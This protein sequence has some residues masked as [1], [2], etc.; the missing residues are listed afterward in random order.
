MAR[1]RRDA[2]TV[3]TFADHEIIVPAQSLRKALVSGDGELG[4]D[5]EAIARAEAALT[6]LSAHFPRWMQEECSRLENACMRVKA[7][8]RLGA[9][10]DDLFRAAHDIKGQASTFGY[11]LAAEAA[12][13][14]CRL[15]EH[16]PDPER[17]P[18]SLIDQHV[19]SVCAI[20]R[21]NARDVHD[22]IASALATGLRQVTDDFLV[23][24]NRHRPDYLDG[25]IIFAPPLAPGL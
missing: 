5:A 1:S 7:S 17:V 18:L 20:I 4:A 21:E 13:S 2:P 11:P 25:I 6:E 16:A 23:Q 22:P 9:H 24:A 15:I 8:G 3:S 10:R 12:D 19:D 14:L